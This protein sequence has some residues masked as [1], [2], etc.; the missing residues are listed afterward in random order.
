MGFFKKAKTIRSQSEADVSAY[1]Q[2]GNMVA[3]GI[4]Q[5]GDFHLALALKPMD[6]RMTATSGVSFPKVTSDAL[7][8]Y[9][10]ISVSRGGELVLDTMIRD[11]ALN[12]HLIQPLGND[13]LLACARSRYRGP[14]DFDKNG[15]VYS[16]TGVLLREFL[17]GDGIQGMQTTD[18][19]T[20]WTSFF[21]EGVFGNFGWD[22][23]IGAHGLV[24]WDQQGKKVF[25][26]DSGE[27]TDPVVDCYAL[28][29]AS[30]D[31][32]CFYYYSAFSLVHINQGR[33][34]SQRK[35]PLRGSQ[36]FAV[37]S[38]HALFY[39][40]YND[41]GTCHLFSLETEPKLLAT[42]DLCDSRG[43]RITAKNV[44]GRGAGLYVLSEKG[45]CYRFTVA[46]AL[47]AL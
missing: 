8:N 2:S 29:V 32:I 6:N 13:L 37:T 20:I 16:R 47:A 27:V 24:A 36:A 46:D 1:L 28:N 40:G 18:D 39:G 33:V 3:W 30:A 14:G 38:E 21:D 45:L 26:L 4:G 12:F 22:N 15:R 10:V 9:R 35:I 41:P 25:E 42:L 5:Q 31:D 7:Q 19:G 17:L 44:E 23:P 43:S 34:A 11:E